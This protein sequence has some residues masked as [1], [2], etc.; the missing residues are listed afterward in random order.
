M[1]LSE[2]P[3]SL[4]KLSNDGSVASSG[5]SPWLILVLNDIP[6]RKYRVIPSDGLV[7]IARE[8]A[9]VMDDIHE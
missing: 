9:V 3:Y 1:V 6:M 4:A 8:V 2:T 7:F 5:H